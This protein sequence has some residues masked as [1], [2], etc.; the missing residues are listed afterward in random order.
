MRPIAGD[1]T[2]GIPFPYTFPFP[3]PLPYPFPFLFACPFPF[4][5][6]RFAAFGHERLDVGPMLKSEESG[7]GTGTGT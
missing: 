3:F 4:P 5:E 7:T 2:L 1:W 6:E